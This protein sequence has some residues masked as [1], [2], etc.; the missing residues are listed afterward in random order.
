MSYIHINEVDKTITDVYP[1]TND[2]I[3][4]IPLNST[5]GPSGVYTVLQSYSDFTRI[6][7]QDPDAGSA[8]MTSWDF[9]AN[10]LLR[11]MP[12]MV[13]RITNFIDDD[14]NDLPVKLDDVENSGPL[15]GVSYASTL[16]KV[17]DTEGL[18]TGTQ[19]K[20]ETPVKYTLAKGWDDTEYAGMFPDTANNKGAEH[21]E[22]IFDKLPGS[23][24]WTDVR[25]EFGVY[26]TPTALDDTNQISVVAVGTDKEI[27]FKTANK[28]AYDESKSEHE[29]LTKAYTS[30]TDG[31]KITIINNQSVNDGAAMYITDLKIVYNKAVRYDAKLSEI[32]FPNDVTELSAESLNKSSYIKIFDI[33]KN[34]IVNKADILVKKIKLIRD[35]KVVEVA[36][37]ELPSNHK[38]VYDAKINMFSGNTA[39]KSD[40]KIQVNVALTPTVAA[41]TFQFNFNDDGQGDYG[42]VADY[43]NDATPDSVKPTIT[44]YEAKTTKDESIENAAAF[45]GNGYINMFKVSYKYAGENGTRLSVNIK[46]VANDSI[47]LQVYNGSQRLENIPLVNLRYK[48]ST[49]S[50]FYNNYD[51]DKDTAKIWNLL[52]N[53]FGISY[54]ISG[55]T[56]MLNLR[57]M[58]TQYLNVELNANIDLSDTRFAKCLYYANNTNSYKLTGGSSASAEDVAHEVYKTYAPLTD[59]YLYDV[60][61]ITNG[62][63]VDSIVFPEHIGEPPSIQY[64][65][66]EDAQISAAET[67]GDALAFIDVPLE[68]P[69]EDTLEYFSRLSTSYATAYAPWIKINLL[70]RESKWCPPSFAALWTIAKSVSRGNKVYAPPAGVNRA[71]LPECTDL[72]FQIPS[73]YI[74]TWSD[75]YT[76]FINPIVYINGYGVNIFGQ[77]TLYSRVDGSYDTK[78]ALQYLNTRLVANEIKKRIFKTCIELT[79]EP[80]NLHT[81]LNFKTKM[82]SLL[83]E[84]Y[85][86]NAITYY[87]IAMDETTMTDSDI[88]S[89]HIVGTVSVA[90]STT[91]EK[92]DITFE[93]LPNQVN[94]LS[95]EDNEEE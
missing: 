77:K 45:D 95:M 61:F 35:G 10:L 93:L 90:V 22:A 60:K 57:P 71:N 64:R 19:T 32:T 6:Y 8:T 82:D 50:R 23:N 83:N 94:F 29:A 34:E 56:A 55:N 78:S 54:P 68:L 38:I 3:A 1:I 39:T 24:K 40:S 70:T 76:Q 53:N 43:I 87:N 48:A 15:P 75:N 31:G 13:R 86:N 84:L 44:Y 67:R 59:K 92:F 63:Y 52:L 66:I 9:A 26:I 4:Y 37:L 65:Y 36:A 42:I 18:G 62:G 89:N 5:D 7:G 81:W 47:Y 74:D 79:F 12:V 28:S 49:G 46:T 33:A 69:I 88:A 27:T 14:G 20:V 80:N 16:L 17:Q 21:F 91:A 85:H 25:G 30:L 41:S 11:N 73:D 58:V 51:I 2:N 72:Y